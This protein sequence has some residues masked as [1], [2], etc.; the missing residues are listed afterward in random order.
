MCAK[1]GSR[2]QIGTVR[3]RLMEEVVEEDAEG[4]S[5]RCSDNDVAKKVH[6]ENN[7]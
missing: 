7:S 6:A 2:V 4:R 1:D 3:D 5:E